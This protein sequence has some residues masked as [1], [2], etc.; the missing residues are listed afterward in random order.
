MFI[1]SM[2]FIF[3]LG[4]LA[5]GAHAESPGTKMPTYPVTK[6]VDLAPAPPPAGNPGNNVTIAPSMIGGT[7]GTNRTPPTQG[8][9]GMTV[10]IPLK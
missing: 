8:A 4:A 9:P 3:G 5:I 1:K 2:I 6:N 10:T 7:P